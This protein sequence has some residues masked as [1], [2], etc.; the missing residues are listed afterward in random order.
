MLKTF[1]LATP[2]PNERCLSLSFTTSFYKIIYSF[3]NQE[4]WNHVN[5]RRY[6]AT[7]SAC[8]HRL[9]VWQP[10]NLLE[11]IHNTDKTEAE[12]YEEIFKSL[13]E[14]HW[15]HVN[16]TT[17]KETKKTQKTP[18]N[19]DKKLFDKLLINSKGNNT[20][21]EK[22]LFSPRLGSFSSSM[23]SVCASLSYSLLLISPLTLWF[24]KKSLKIS[25]AISLKFPSSSQLG[26]HAT[27]NKR[28]P[29]YATK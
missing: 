5:F 6:F 16:L 25:G 27:W 22:T 11:C 15:F 3:P 20:S 19:R 7:Y 17:T 24:L 2:F 21:S 29:F 9:Q 4:E 12:A 26:S 10:V 13:Y 23:T 14:T 8:K 1:L 18:T 28:L